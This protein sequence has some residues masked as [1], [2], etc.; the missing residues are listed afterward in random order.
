MKISQ[1]PPEIKEK[2]IAYREKFNPT[3]TTD[4]LHSAFPWEKPDTEEGF[5]YWNEWYNKPYDLKHQLQQLSTQ[6]PN[7]LEF[8]AQVR[9]LISEL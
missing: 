5:D 4:Y 1:L 9:K 7:D 2:A 6:Y 3:S 8:G